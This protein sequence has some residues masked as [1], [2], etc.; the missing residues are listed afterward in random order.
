MSEEKEGEIQN[1]RE[2]GKNEVRR[3]SE[4]VSGERKIYGL[5]IFLSRSRALQALSPI[6]LSCASLFPLSS[7]ARLPILALLG[8]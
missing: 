5:L 2:R 7:R 8:I 6:M 4:T 3:D 1:L